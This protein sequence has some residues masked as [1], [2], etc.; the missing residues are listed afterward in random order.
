MARL[1][2]IYLD[3]DTGYYPGVNHGLASLVGAIRERGH[4]VSFHHLTSP[5]P[6]PAVIRR[7]QEAG[8]DIIGFSFTSPQKRF[9]AQYAAALHEALG[10]VQ[11]A[12]GLHPTLAPEEVLE[13]AGVSGACLGEAEI[14]GP[15]LLANFDRGLDLARTPGFWWR[16]PDGEVIRNAIPPLEANLANLPLPD[17][18]IFDTAVIGEASW[19]W[20]FVMV[21]RGCPYDCS[22]CCNHVLRQIYP[23]RKHYV[24]LPP[25][26]HAL[27]VI[28]HSL[29]YYAQVKGIIFDDD[30]L[31]LNPAWFTQF[32]RQYHRTIKLPY[33][34]NLRVENAT[35]AVIEALK[36]SGCTMVHLGIES[37]NEWVRRHL[38]NRPHRN[39]DILECCTR[40]KQAGLAFST[41]NIVGFPFETKEQ[42]EETFKINKM[43]EQDFGIVF[44]FYPFPGTRLFKLCKEYDLLLDEVEMTQAGYI[45]KPSIKPVHCSLS[46]C[47]RIYRKIRLLLAAKTIALGFRLPR[48]F[49]QVIYGIMNLYPSFFVRLITKRSD[50]KNIIRKIAY[51]L[52][53]DKQPSAR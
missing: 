38:L 50:L 20:I 39:R 2:L 14:S 44:Y 34:C 36:E 29:T 7:A 31:M 1:H 10:K 22:Y 46:D 43:I 15:E 42:M 32:A 30:L 41:Y 21:T 5:E 35:P 37:G 45:E 28:Q 48:W 23:N 33:T 27:K 26:D 47:I 40:L 12:G 3:I 13:M 18:S 19:W 49:A 6:A 4:F 11:I 16:R 24:R 53:F 52:I 17:Y 51:I 8:P 25:V 9:A